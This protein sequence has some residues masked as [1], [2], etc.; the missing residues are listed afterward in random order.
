MPATFPPAAFK[1]QRNKRVLCDKVADFLRKAIYS[2]NLKSGEPLVSLQ[3]AQICRVSR[4]PVRDA[5]A[6]LEQEGLAYRGAGDTLTVVSLTRE[7]VELIWKLRRSLEELTVQRTI[8]TA[9]EDDLGLLQQTIDALEGTVWPE[10]TF[11]DIQFHDALVQITA[12][13]RLQSFWK[14]LRSQ[15]CL[16]M[17]RENRRHTDYAQSV[18]G[19][20]QRLLNLIRA[21]DEVAAVAEMGRQLDTHGVDDAFQ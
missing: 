6:V 1:K 5:L 13:A 12:N 3:I 17:V 4:G 7:D 11:I 21:R 19:N 9:T 8:R 16:V 10:T 15:I 18:A 2:G 14:S 20:H